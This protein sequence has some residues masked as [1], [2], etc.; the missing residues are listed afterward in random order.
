MKQGVS[1]YCVVIKIS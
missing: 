1:A